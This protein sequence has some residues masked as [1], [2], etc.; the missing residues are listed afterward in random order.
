M[1]HL[2]LFSLLLL[3]LMVLAEKPSASMSFQGYSGIINTPTATLFDEG[4]FHFQYGNQV[5]TPGG[6]RS[7]SNYNFGVG[8][9]EYIEVSGR[10]ADYDSGSKYGI[11]DLSANV[12]LSIPY[13]PKDWFSLALGIQDLGGAANHFDSQFVVASKSILDVFNLSLGYGKSN[14]KQGRM[15]GIFSGIEWQPYQWFKVSA[16]NDAADTQFAMHFSTPKDWTS[17]GIQLSTDIMVSSTND[18]LN[19]ELYYGI[20]LTLPIDFY[21]KNNYSPGMVKSKKTITPQSR[22]PEQKIRAEDK[23][24][25][26]DVNEPTSS[27]SASTIVKQEGIQAENS[28]DIENKEQVSN[29]AA[30]MKVKTSLAKEGFESIIVGEVNHSTLYIELENHIYNQNQ[31]D[32][33]G[34]A[35]GIISDNLQEHYSAFKFV[36][37]ERE[38]PVLVVKG[39]L[40]DYAEFLTADV[41]LKLEISTD[42]SGSQQGILS[43]QF[44]DTNKGWLLKPRITFWPGITSRVG[45]ELGVFDASLA[46][47]THIELPLW[48]GAALTAQHTTQVAETENFKDGEFFGDEKQTNGFKHYSFHQTLSLPYSVKN[49]TSVGKYRETYNFVS[50]DMRWQSFEGSHKINFYAAIY[51]NQ[52][53]AKRTPYPGCNIL[54]SFCWPPKEPQKREVIIGKYK[55][56]NALLNASAELQV[57]KFWQRDNGYVVNLERMFG[58]VTLNLTYKDTRVADEEANQF[59]GLGFSIPLTPR[60]DY[61]NKYF[62]VRG[63]PKW[64]YSVNTLV[65]KSHNKLTPGSGD[66]TQQFYNLD[67]AFYNN[68][69]LGSEY[70]YENA[71]RLRQAYFLSISDD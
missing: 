18:E 23:P 32:G 35:L 57:G 39:N 12:K 40:A 59:I 14:S 34:V 1:K 38:I 64:Q 43:A 56:Y 15:N 19:D 61:N 31:I 60:K 46:L 33:I 16:E 42:T 48:Q 17:I 27:S 55:Y 5:E 62:Q 21:S 22:P 10:L 30:R 37:K 52:I 25:S 20:G 41:P 71:N 28:N 67:S 3:P 4:T 58:D 44:D 51:E 8:L 6:Y 49:M 24:V 11:T 53:T 2:S 66:N 68:D 65:G 29:T 69:R 54:F 26:I 7:G 36:L 47:I 13:I 9:W 63:K 70:I 45:T 50:N